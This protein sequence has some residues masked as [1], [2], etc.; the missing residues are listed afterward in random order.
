M[1]SDERQKS[2]VALNNLI[3]E[4]QPIIDKHVDEMDVR[5]AKYLVDNYSKY[6]RINLL[7]DIGRKAAE[8]KYSS[9]FDDLIDN[10]DIGDYYGDD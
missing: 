2:L 5:S 3:N 8:H 7:E 9:P 1:S 10:V 4:V 6:L